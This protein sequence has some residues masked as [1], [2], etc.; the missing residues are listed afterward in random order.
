[1]AIYNAEGTVYEIGE[2]KEGVTNERE[3]KLRGFVIEEKREHQGKMYSDFLDVTCFGQQA[4]GLADVNV[5]DKVEIGFTVRSQKKTSQA[6]N[7]YW[8]TS[9]RCISL[10]V[11]DADAPP[12]A[13]AEPQQANLQP[14]DDDLPF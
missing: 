13:K 3:W 7:E 12:A 14:Q 5:G 9:A 2:L 6:G 11:L 4:D 10:K 1:M 8:G